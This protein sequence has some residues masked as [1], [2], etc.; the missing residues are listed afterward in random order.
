[1]LTEFWERIDKHSKN[2]NKELEGIQKNQANC[3][4]LN[5]N[6]LEGIN[7]RVVDTGECISNL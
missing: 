3:N 4:N 5:E 1:M 6:I 7:R 2:F